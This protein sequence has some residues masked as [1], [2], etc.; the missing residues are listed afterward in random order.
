[1]AAVQWRRCTAVA[2]LMVDAFEGDAVALLAHLEQRV[3]DHRLVLYGIHA[4]AGRNGM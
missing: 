4:V 1:M 2:Y 3:C